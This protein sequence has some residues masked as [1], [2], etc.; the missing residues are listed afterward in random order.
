MT[1]IWCTVPEIQSETGNIFCHF[2]TFLPFQPPDNLKN[3]NFRI[4]KNTWIYYHFT[5]LHYKS[6]AYDVWFLRNGAW[7]TEFF[8][9]L[10][11][12]LPFYLTPYGPRKSQ[13][14]KNKKNTWRYYH[15]ANIND[16]HMMHGSWDMMM[17][18]WIVFVVWLIN[19]RHLALF[20]ARIIVRDPHDLKSL[21]CREQD[22]NLHR[23]WVQA[24]LNEVVQ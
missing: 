19:E 23:T 8:V 24:L 18:N 3:Q 13:F 6:Q 9:I 7:Q 11:H 16:S 20:P 22:L 4:E 21:T 14:W 15:F 1:I 17:M 10:D 2:G 12:F 5:H